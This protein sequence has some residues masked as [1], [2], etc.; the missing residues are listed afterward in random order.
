MM[1]EPMFSLTQDQIGRVVA[2]FYSKARADAVLGPI[3]AER[4]TDWPAHEAKIANFWSNAILR[5]RSYDGNPM[6]AHISAGNVEAG[7]FAAWLAMF[8]AVLVDELPL[9][10]A[11][12]WSRLAHRIGRGLMSGLAF[13]LGQQNDI[14]RLRS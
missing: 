7:H 4:V 2:Q 9:E 14:P 8:D 6:Q 5:T 3:F 11:M 1:P 13:N 12:A 10:P